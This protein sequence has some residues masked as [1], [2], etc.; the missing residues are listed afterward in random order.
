MDYKDVCAGEE[1][2]WFRLSNSKKEGK[3]F[4]KWAKDLGCMWINGKEIDPQNDT[5]FFTLSISSDGKLSNVPAIALVSRQFESV[6]RVDFITY[7]KSFKKKLK[8]SNCEIS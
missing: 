8:T 2:V 5:Y 4:L 3:F 1:N 7:Y 6:K